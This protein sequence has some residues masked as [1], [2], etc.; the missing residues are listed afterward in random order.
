MLRESIRR[1][2]S[3]SLADRLLN[4]I[5]LSSQDDKLIRLTQLIKTQT[6]Q[7][8]TEDG[9]LISDVIRRWAIEQPK[10]VALS[11]GK[12]NHGEYQQFT[13]DELHAQ[14]SRFAN[15]LAGKD[16]NL[17]PGNTVGS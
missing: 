5:Q 14:A 6:Q 12:P 7:K 10:K 4:I 1:I 11:T 2:S 3:K 8:D 15:V 17:K 9:N 16:F 13:F